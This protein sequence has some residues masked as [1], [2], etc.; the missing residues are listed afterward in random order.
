MTI[1]TSQSVNDNGFTSV[2]NAESAATASAASVDVYKRLLTF[3]LPYWKVFVLA[4]LCMVLFAATQPAFAA[5][6]K[7]ILDG[8]FVKKDPESIRV[9]PLILIGVFMLRSVVGFCSRYTMEWIAKAVVK[10]LRTVLFGRLLRLPSTFYDMNAGGRLLSKLTYDVEQIAGAATDSITVMIRDSLSVVGLLG[11]MFWLNWKLALIFCLFGPLMA[12][13]I[14]LLGKRFRLLGKRIQHSRG[15]ITQVTEEAIEGHIVT[16]I[17]NGQLF[18]SNEFEKA[19]EKI[20]RLGMK[21]ALADTAGTYIIQLMMA[22]ALAGILVSATTIAAN[23]ATTVGGFVSFM[24]AMMMLMEPIKRLTKLNSVLQRGLAAATGIFALMDEPPEQDKGTHEVGRAR[25]EIAYKGVTF[26]YLTSAAPVIRNVSVN[27]E[28]GATVAFVGRSGGGKSTLTSLLPRLYDV[29]EGCITLDGVDIRHYSL[30]SLR[31]QIA[32]VS[33]HVILFNDT[34]GNN[35]AYA[36]KGGASVEELEEVANAAHAMEFIRKFPLGLNTMI[37]DNGV[38]LS[39][40]QRQRLAIARALLKDAPVL[41]LDE[42]TASLDTESEIHIQQALDNLMQ[43][44]TTLVIAHRLST[45]ENADKILVVDEGEIVESGQHQELLALNG[46]YARLH[47]MQFRESAAM[48][49]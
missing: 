9:L 24:M 11:W 5:L 15:D 36:R 19:N 37:G 18:E 4:V 8:S 13:C 16:K 1:S 10:D 38:L 25:G 48:A 6:M 29:S 41:I 32:L 21:W 42:A 39:G 44:R 7:P 45:I 31:N 20:R 35:I 43:N 17:F 49:S 23:E 22:F 33:Q 27:I 14:A 3:S 26:S 30:E 34:I 47:S 46:I 2:A 40:G 28:P 12:L